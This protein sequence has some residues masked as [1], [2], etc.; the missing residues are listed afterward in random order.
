MSESSGEIEKAA[1]V[2]YEIL[3]KEGIEGIFNGT[4]WGEL[5]EHYK[6]SYRRL[7]RH[8]ISAYTAALGGPEAG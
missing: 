3:C 7:A 5:P 1:Q 2:A 6:G 4:P 8:T